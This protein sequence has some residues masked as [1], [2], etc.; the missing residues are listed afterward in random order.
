MFRNKHARRTKLLLFVLVF[1]SA[2]LLTLVLT[3]ASGPRAS[4]EPEQGAA[5]LPA[6]VVTD[7]TASGGGYIKF[8]TPSSCPTPAPTTAAA[9]EQLIRGGIGGKKYTAD[10]G[11]STRLPNG[12]VLWVFGDTFVR[13]ET[14][15]SGGAFI[16]NNF[17]LV[18]KGCAQAVSGPNDAQGQPTSTVTPTGSFDK[19]GVTDYYWPNIPYIDG[20]TLNV[21]MWHMYND[22]SGFHMIG[23][24]LA[25]FDVSGAVPVLTSLHQTPGSA[26]G[27]TQP[28]WGS[29]VLRADDFTYIY[30]NIDKYEEWVFGKYYY[31]ARVPN[32]QVASQAAWRYWDGANWVANQTAAA[33]VIPGTAGVGAVSSVY[34]RPNGSYV[35]VSKKFDMVGSDI[36]AWTAS[37]PTGPWIESSTLIAPVPNVDTAAGEHT[38]FGLAHPEVPLA[39]GKMLISWS[40]NSNDPGF[41]GG[42]RYGLYFG[43]STQP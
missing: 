20:N 1:A 7:G 24:D 35:L 10:S 5:S 42:P 31:V 6:Q 14:Q 12:K 26:N 41:F 15:S 4:V 21:F 9:Y 29:A 22:D 16:N 28:G 17:I 39:S 2:G 38:Y 33:A 43:E 32:G 23:Q 18:D 34:Q 36:V 30:G 40:L 19:P 37:S 8:G 11:Q 3:W 27:E 13:P 25:Q